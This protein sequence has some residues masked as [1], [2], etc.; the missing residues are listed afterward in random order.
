[1]SLNT[2]YNVVFTNPRDDRKFRCLASQMHPN[3]FYWLIGG[4]LDAIAKPHEYIVLDHYPKID[5]DKRVV[6]IF[7]PVEK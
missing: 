6:T 3:K 2:L 4:F 1:M 5:D 7:Y